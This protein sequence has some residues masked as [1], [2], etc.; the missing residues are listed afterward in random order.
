MQLFRDNHPDALFVDM[1]NLNGEENT[2]LSGV[3]VEAL[4]EIYAET[5]YDVV[6]AGLN[7]LLF[8][9]IL[10]AGDGGSGIPFV[11]ANLDGFPGDIPQ[12][13]DVNCS[14]VVVRITGVIADK[15]IPDVLED[16]GYK[17]TGVKK[18]V[19]NVSKAPGD[20]DLLVVLAANC[21]AS[22][23]RKIAY[24][25]RKYCD[26]IIAGGGVGEVPAGFTDIDKIVTI[27]SPQWS[28]FVGEIKI[29]LDEDNKVVSWK[30]TY[31][32]VTEN[33]MQ[34]ERT[35]YI[36]DQYYGELFT[37]INTQN[38][39]A[40][41]TDLHP[42]GEFRGNGSCAECHT[43]QYQQWL[44]TDHARAYQSL[45]DDGAARNPECVKCHVTGYSYVGG[46]DPIKPEVDFN[47]VGCEE[48]HGPGSNHISSPTENETALI[49]EDTCLRCHS[50][51]NSPGFEYGNY[52]DKV[53]H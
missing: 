53:T 12:Y 45:A 1:G 39:L 10:W 52:L 32:P 16:N 29:G 50:G 22:Y 18:A 51:I 33:T 35:A 37:I 7:D 25:I 21:D 44:A 49:N 13:I 34:D 4:R 40:E 43:E 19:K 8:A 47:Y 48:C 24:D 5:G 30:N 15:N 14:G 23:E 6:N 31:Y 2:L 20:Y 38:L 11:A 3:K 9:D 36:I 46:F 27:Y 41:P 17:K 28:R 26:V 42:D